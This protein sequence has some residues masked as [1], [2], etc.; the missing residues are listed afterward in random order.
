[1]PRTARVVAEM[2]ERVLRI[3]AAAIKRMERDDPALLADFHGLIAATLARRLGRTTALL[4]DAEPAAEVA[5]RQ[6][7]SAERTSSR[8]W[9]TS[10]EETSSLTQRFVG[11]THLA[12]LA[13]G[14]DRRTDA[15]HHAG[16]AME[17]DGGGREAEVRD[18]VASSCAGAARA[19]GR[20]HH[21][22]FATALR[23]TAVTRPAGPISRWAPA[24]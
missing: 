24:R 8:V 2:S 23:V 15:A 9:A 10:A 20:A 19:P 11:A 12:A 17:G 1:M 21:R 5:Q 14:A 6:A 3:D 4:A 22:R 7:A 16:R 18:I 13:G